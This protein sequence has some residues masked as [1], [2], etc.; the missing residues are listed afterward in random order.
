MNAQLCLLRNT[1][2]SPFCLQTVAKNHLTISAW[3]VSVCLEFSVAL[4]EM[5]PLPM[6]GCRS[7]GECF[8]GLREALGLDPAPQNKANKK[9]H[10]PA[11]QPTTTKTNQSKA[12]IL[13]WEKNS[14]N[15]HSAKEEM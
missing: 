12:Y 3:R 6:P 11:N 9:H 4:S 5:P 1:T 2:F 8:S 10:Q 7:V 14:L 13:K 15:I